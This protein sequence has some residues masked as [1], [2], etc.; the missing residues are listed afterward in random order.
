MVIHMRNIFLISLLLLIVCS[1]CAGRAAIP[2]EVADGA[3]LPAAEA[4][5]ETIS[6][7]A[8]AA[9]GKD[10]KTITIP[11]PI[12]RQRLVKSLADTKRSEIVNGVRLDVVKGKVFIVGRVT[13]MRQRAMVEKI[14]RTTPGVKGVSTKI[15]VIPVRRSYTFKGDRR[16]LGLIAEDNLAKDAI[17]RR[18]AKS[19]Y[20][21][22]SRIS[23]DVYDG[24]AVLSGYVRSAKEKRTARDL[25]MFTDSIKAV[26]NN[27]VVDKPK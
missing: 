5:A 17:R 9:L 26:V 15:K 12:L 24:V 3:E 11:D 1:S 19:P 2:G 10:G 22:S 23:I 13:N 14:A 21:A 18:L 16:T 7:Q 4:D 6:A 20:V 27:L 8:A 25:A